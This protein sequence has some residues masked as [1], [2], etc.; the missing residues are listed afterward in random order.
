MGHFYVHFAFLFTLKGNGIDCSS[1]RQTETLADASK[2]IPER[3]ARTAGH[4]STDIA[5]L[6]ECFEIF[7][8]RF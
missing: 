1:Q 7:M 8:S 2:H 5:T 4:R 3:N 6:S